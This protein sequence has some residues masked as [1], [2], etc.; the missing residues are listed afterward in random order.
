MKH[1]NFGWTVANVVIYLL[2][3]MILFAWLTIRASNGGFFSSSEAKYKVV[4]P[5]A[6]G[7][8]ANKTSVLSPSGVRVGVVTDVA[9]V[10]NGAALELKITQPLQIYEDGSAKIVVSNVI[11]EKAV[12]IDSGTDGSPAPSGMTLASSQGSTIV[13][14]DQALEPL[15]QL[16]D[17]RSDPEVRRIIDEQKGH[18]DNAKADVAAINDDLSTLNGLMSAQSVALNNVLGRTNELVTNLSGHGGDI[19]SVLG[20]TAG[21]AYD[22]NSLL[23]GELDM[24]QKVLSFSADAL[25]ILAAHQGEL[26]YVLSEMPKLLGLVQSTTDEL[27]KMFNNEK[28]HYVFLGVTNLVDLNRFLEILQGG[29]PP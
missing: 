8:E 6:P 11:G 26:N 18:I 24:V 3:A 12:V 14:P 9:L 28:G 7:V 10:D 1:R 15:Q 17:L 4:L 27:V 20:Q 22:V 13:N 16:E 23:D 21:L 25:E 2:G 29:T 19:E 5:T